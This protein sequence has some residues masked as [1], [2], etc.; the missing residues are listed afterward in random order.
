[1]E[2]FEEGQ[3]SNIPVIAD[4]GIKFSGD[5]AKAMAAGAEAVMGGDG[6]GVVFSAGDG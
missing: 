1:M 6:W 2:A 4:G 5:L 3:K